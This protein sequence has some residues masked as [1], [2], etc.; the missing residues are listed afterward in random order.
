MDW[1]RGAW[2]T[3]KSGVENA[4][5]KVA[6]EFTDPNSVLRHGVTDAA[7][8][9]EHE[10]TDPNSVLRHGV[11]DAAGKVAHEFTDKDSILR[12]KV[13]PMAAK[14]ANVVTPFLSE[15]PIVGQVADAVDA[16]LNIANKANTAAKTVGFGAHPRRRRRRHHT[17][18]EMDGSAVTGG[19]MTGEGKTARRRSRGGPVGLRTRVAP[20][21]TQ[22]RNAIVRKIMSEKGLKM[23]EASKYVK[24]HGLWKRG[25]GAGAE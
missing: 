25:G 8:K 15:I 17:A 22:Q 16:G 18:G 10:F 7:K 2:N 19:A 14:V 23:I 1:I 5:G 6:H 11:A 21:H 24:E 9:V 20:L 12:G 3:V 13:L 4:A